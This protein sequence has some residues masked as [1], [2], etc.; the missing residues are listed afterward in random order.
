[1]TL[2][3]NQFSQTTV[4]GEPD[5]QFSGSVVSARV[6]AN[7]ATAL[8]AGQAVKIENSGGQGLPN[9]LATANIEDDVWGV[10]LR[11]LKDQSFAAGKTLEIGRD[12][13]VVY[14]TASGAIARGAPVQID[15]TAFTVAAWN[16]FGSVIGEAYDQA[17]NNGDLIRVWLRL[18]RTGNVDRAVQTL[19]VVATLAQIN[20]G[21]EVIPS[22]AGQQIRVLSYVAKV[23]G[24]FAT[25]TSIEL[26][27]DTTAVAVTSIAE[28]GLT[29]GATLLPS[30]ANTTLGAGFASLL[31]AGEGLKLVNNGTAQ[32]GGT[33]VEFIVT[34]QQF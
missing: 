18:G 6:S 7:Q 29:N 34:Y 2:N 15:P 11:N 22:E 4:A 9:V 1:M 25:G 26:E 5:S 20:A 30:S 3:I 27:S 14:L 33:S 16:G 24:A 10:V 28:A 13:T 19:D 21:L 12:G 8:V 31:P 17:V 23:I 32:T